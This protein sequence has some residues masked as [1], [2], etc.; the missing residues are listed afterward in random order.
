[1]QTRSGEYVRCF[2]VGER[3]RYISRNNEMPPALLSDIVQVHKALGHPARIRILAMLRPGELC[4]CQIIAVLRLA[5]STVSAHLAELR[6]AELVA[7]RKDGRWVYYRLARSEGARETVDGL[8]RRIRRDPQI[9]GD[10]GLVKQ[11]RGIPV[12]QLCRADQDIS[13]LTVS[14]TAK[15]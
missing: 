2:C 6:R 12:E 7:E 10:T 14:K 9:R 15:T 1:M 4:A 5:P 13:Q 11:I 3:Y 8:W